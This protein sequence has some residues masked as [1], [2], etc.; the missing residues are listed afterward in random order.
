MVKFKISTVSDCLFILLTSFVL[1]FTIS[2]YLLKNNVTAILLSL[3]LSLITF[4]TY[5]IICKNKRGK[6]KV[7][8]EDEERFLKCTN[9]LCLAS[10][11]D[12]KQV[13]FNTLERLNKRPLLTDD[14]I[15]CENDFFYV[16]FSYDSITIGGVTE[17][18]KKT[19]KGKN[20]F[21]VGV[22]YSQEAKDFADGFSNRIKLIPLNEL[23]PVLVKVHTLPEGGTLPIKKKV[24][25]IQLVK[26]SFNKEKARKFALYG[27]FLLVMSRFVFFPIWYIISGSTFLI[28]AITIKFFAPKPIEKTFI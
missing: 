18:Y 16:N 20:L 5:M 12:S 3:P 10:E 11:K 24:G 22:S 8:R 23:F 19:P 28:Y 9:A 13:V 4:C 17:A 14:G 7:K 6:L 26:Q 2:F 1:F 25:F 15:I 21:Y 27:G